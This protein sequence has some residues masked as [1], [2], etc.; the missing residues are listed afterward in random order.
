M[1]IVS[2]LLIRVWQTDRQKTDRR[3]TE[4][5]QTDRLDNYYNPLMHVHWG[6]M[7]IQLIKNIIWNSSWFKT[8]TIY[9]KHFSK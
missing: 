4:D 2:I 8:N 1:A 6:L 7:K 9:L 3:Q 5:R